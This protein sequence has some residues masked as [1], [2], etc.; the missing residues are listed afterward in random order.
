MSLFEVTINKISFNSNYLRYIAIFPE[1]DHTESNL[2]YYATFK[3]GK[4]GPD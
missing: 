3:V 4:Y 1:P 2:M